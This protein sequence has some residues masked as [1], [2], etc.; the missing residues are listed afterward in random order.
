M[1]SSA[2]RRRSGIIAGTTNGFRACGHGPADGNDAFLPSIVMGRD[3][4]RLSA[5]IDRL[6]NAL[7]S[8]ISWL[9]RPS[10]R[11]ARIPAGILLVCGGLLFILPFLGIWMLPLGLMLL[12]EDVPALRRVRDGALDWIAHHRPHWLGEGVSRRPN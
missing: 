8:P 1:T 6:P 12:A 9:R 2:D 11:W 7:R 4:D 5:L 3:K 10:S